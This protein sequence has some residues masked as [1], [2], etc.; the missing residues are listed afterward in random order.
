[1]SKRL[2]NL[3]DVKKKLAA[4]YERLSVLSGS[5]TRSRRLKH[6]ADFYRRQVTALQSRE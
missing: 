1:M 5:R 4:K 2:E 6:R 3:I